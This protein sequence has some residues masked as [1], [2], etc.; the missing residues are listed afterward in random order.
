MAF[1]AK[2]RADENGPSIAR[3]FGDR[4][5]LSARTALQL[6]PCVQEQ[7]SQKKPRERQGACC[8]QRSSWPDRVFGSLAGSLRSLTASRPELALGLPR[9]GI[10]FAHKLSEKNLVP[11]INSLRHKPSSVNSPRSTD[12]GEME[13]EKGDGSN[14]CE[15][16]SGPF[17]QIGPV[18]FFPQTVASSQHVPVQPDVA[19]DHSFHAEL[20][21]HAVASGGR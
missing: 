3:L 9:D 17:R 5:Y 16:P 11:S 21:F 14:L 13:G 2:R 6:P 20:A 15:A 19:F 1:L 7:T 18:P 4:W 10:G 12:T 8:F